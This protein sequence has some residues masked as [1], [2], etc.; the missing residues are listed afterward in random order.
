MRAHRPLTDRLL[1]QQ[2]ARGF[3]LVEMAVVVGVLV[4]VVGLLAPSF[5]E[6]LAS[7]QAKALS[8]DLVSDLLLAR[9]EALKRNVNVAVSAAVTG[10]RD[11]WSVATV[12]TPQTLSRRN[13]ASAAVTVSGAPAAITFDANGRVAAPAAPVRITVSSHA[14]SRCVAL[15]LSGRARASFGACT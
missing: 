8:Q 5:V 12:A 15:D 9:N 3:T 14:S 11:G 6:F 10:W 4:L 2:R 13:A 7:Q 1:G